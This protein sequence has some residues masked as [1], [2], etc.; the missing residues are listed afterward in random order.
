MT[1]GHRIA[2]IDDDSIVR[3]ALADYLPAVAEAVAY[4]SVRE[5]L[6][7]RPRVGVVVLDLHLMG[8]L[9]PLDPD[10]DSS[11]L[12][13]HGAAAV[14]MVDQAGYKVLIYTNEPRRFVL[15]GCLA[16]GA[17]GV[18]HKTDRMETLDAAITEVISGGIVVTPGLVGMIEMLDRVGELPSLT[19]R[20]REVLAGR[21]RGE[22]FKLLARRLEIQQKTVEEHAGA[23]ARKFSDYLRTHSMADLERLLGIG[24]GDLLS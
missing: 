12:P 7:A 4:P 16:A 17:S 3:V 22:P 20:Q 11:Q 15:A 1:I 9:D 19:R 5:F 24:P 2:I 6:A 10:I 21:A 8:T 13:P 23:V 18:V 14:A